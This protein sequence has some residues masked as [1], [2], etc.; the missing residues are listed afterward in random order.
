MVT[1]SSQNTILV[2]ED[3]FFSRA[4]LTNL[5]E[6]AGFRVVAAAD[7]SQALKTIQAGVLPDLILLDMLLPILDGWHFLDNIRANPTWS[8]I[9]IIVMTGIIL[10]PEWAQDHGCS[11]FLRKP[12]ERD[13]LFEQI[14]QC[15]H[16]T[17]GQRT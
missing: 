5:L 13:S 3:D 12:I 9:P 14:E 6:A 16:V 7:G 8:S 15:L 10:S 4:G 11:G 1:G 2:V 17:A